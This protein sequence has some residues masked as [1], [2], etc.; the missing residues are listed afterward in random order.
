MTSLTLP[1]PP[2]LLSP[3][4][5]SAMTC[6]LGFSLSSPSYRRRISLMSLGTAAVAIIPRVLFAASAKWHQSLKKKRDGRETE[7]VAAAATEGGKREG[8]DTVGKLL[9]KLH[10]EQMRWK[11]SVSVTNMTINI[12]RLE[13]VAPADDFYLLPALFERLNLQTSILIL[14]LFAI[15]TKFDAGLCWNVI[16]NQKIKP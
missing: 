14:A 13:H 6:L 9:A 7:S 16:N 12:G 8:A 15:L 1:D 3:L 2:P 11:S 4:P 10:L 5:S